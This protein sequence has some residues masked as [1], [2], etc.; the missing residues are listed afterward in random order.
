[1]TGNRHVRFC[2]RVGGGDASRLVNGVGLWRMVA[3]WE[4][5]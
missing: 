2:R 3:Y 1:M 4:R 5:R